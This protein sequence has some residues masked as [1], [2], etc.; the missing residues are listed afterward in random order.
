MIYLAM[1]SVARICI[2]PI[3]DYFGYDNQAR[4]NRPST[5]GINWKWRLKPGEITDRL[6]AQIEDVTT[7]YGRKA[8]HPAQSDQKTE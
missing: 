1:D 6:L 4:M 3:Q 7:L 5:L 2:I 8:W